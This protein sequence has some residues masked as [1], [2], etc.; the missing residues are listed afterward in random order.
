MIKDLIVNL[1]LIYH[2]NNDDFIFFL[3]I[4]LQ[5]IFYYFLNMKFLVIKI[6]KVNLQNFNLYLIYLFFSILK[7]FQIQ[8]L[9]IFLL[10]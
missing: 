9:L 3:L 8:F 5:Q 4:I 6:I 7:N 1:E 10:L 2:L